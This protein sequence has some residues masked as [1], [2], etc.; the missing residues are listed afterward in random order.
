MT[1]T[2]LKD[3]IFDIEDDYIKGSILRIPISKVIE[4]TKLN[5]M[6]VCKMI[7]NSQET[8]YDYYI[9]GNFIGA[10]RNYV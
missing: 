7:N 5:K 4:I 6:N 8:K 10:N 1:T 2:E 9:I 3:V